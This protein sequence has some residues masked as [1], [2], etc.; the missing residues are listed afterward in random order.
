MIFVHQET[1]FC[2]VFEWQRES[3]KREWLTGMGQGKGVCPAAF[4]AGGPAARQHVS[5]CA[6]L[7]FSIIRPLERAEKVDDKVCSAHVRREAAA[8][9]RLGG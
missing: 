2:R 6:I 9:F 1:P 8:P 4:A 5:G 7:G 3:G